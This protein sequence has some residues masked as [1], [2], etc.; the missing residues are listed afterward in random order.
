MYA[1]GDVAHVQLLGEEATPYGG[2]HLLR[3]AAVEQ[4]HPVGL[5]AGIEGEDAHGELLIAPWMLATEVDELT[6]GD[7]EALG[8]MPEV[9]A[10]EVLCEVVVPC[11]H[12]R[13]HSV[14]RGGAHQLEGLVEATTLALHVVQ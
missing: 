8:Q 2:E 6:P 13:V 9:L 14:E 12:G 5:L 7:P 3:H 11:R 4:A 10:E 1:V